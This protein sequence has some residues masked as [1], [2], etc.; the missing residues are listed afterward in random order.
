[1]KESSQPEANQKPETRNQK[2]PFEYLVSGFWFA[3]LAG[4]AQSIPA[5]HPS[6]RPRPCPS[7][8]FDFARRPAENIPPLN[9][10]CS[11]LTQYSGLSSRNAYPSCKENSEEAAHETT[12]SIL[13]AVILVAGFATSSI[14]KTPSVDIHLAQVGSSN[15]VF[16]LRGPISV[17]YQ[18]TID[19]PASDTLTLRRLDLQS[20]GPGAYFIRTGST[21]MKETIRPNGSTTITLSAWGT[22]R[23][24]RLTVDEPV[25]IRGVAQ[26]EDGHG[27]TFNRI[28]TTTLSQFGRE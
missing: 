26:F 13:A 12:L 3:V 11:Y 9:A 19:N 7:P 20:I 1:V 28:F 2:E 16:Y 25:T 4:I 23:G 24:G 22:A 18:L 21:P 15:D 5:R 8:V 6:P 10:P 27:H 17:Q 14:A